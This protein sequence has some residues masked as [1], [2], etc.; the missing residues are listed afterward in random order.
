[1]LKLLI[2]IRRLLNRHLFLFLLPASTVPAA[3]LLSV[4]QQVWA[5]D[6]KLEAIGISGDTYFPLQTVLRETGLDNLKQQLCPP[7][8]IETITEQLLDYYTSQ[9]FAFSRVSIDKLLLD[10]SLK[11]VSLNLTF[12]LGSRVTVSFVTYDSLRSNRPE[13]LTRETRLQVPFIFDPQKVTAA[14]QY[15]SSAELFNTYPIWQIVKNPVGNYGLNFTLAEEPY[16]SLDAVLGYSRGKGEDGELLGRVEVA[17]RNL[18]GTLRQLKINWQRQSESEE[19]VE[20][21]YREPWVFS[22]PFALYGRFKQEFQDEN[23]LERSY[24]AGVDYQLDYRLTLLAEYTFTE[25]LPDSIMISRGSRKADK[26][27]WTAGLNYKHFNRKREYFRSKLTLS[28]V[29]KQFRDSSTENGYLLH[30]FNEW[31]LNIGGPFYFRQ[32]L[33]LEY[34][35]ADSLQSYDLLKFGGHSSLRGYFEDQYRS[36]FYL[37]NRNDL[38]WQ[39]AD[40]TE[41]FVFGD[42]AGYNNTPGQKSARRIDMLYGAG[43][44]LRFNNKLGTFEISYGIAAAEG[45]ETAKLH[46]QYI[47]KF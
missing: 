8:K 22:Y 18:A 29:L 35:E 1:M 12:T 47:N 40:N 5:D 34:T 2:K 42:A 46:M 41:L 14:E 27:I 31:Q 11:T 6:Y 33:R 19:L 44:G 43:A 16:N 25:I 45:N 26:Q 23:Y 4:D 39:A 30:S 7:E 13:Y 9:G 10:D 15:L 37:L 32:Q 38:I 21:Y 36:D 3:E 17:F 20:L 24:G 28:T